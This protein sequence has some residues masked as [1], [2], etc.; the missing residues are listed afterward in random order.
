[1]ITMDNFFCQHCGENPANLWVTK[2]MDGQV[3]KQHLCDECFRKLSGH[4]LPFTLALPI[5][6]MNPLIS[7]T[8]TVRPLKS[9]DFQVCKNCSTSWHDFMQTGFLGCPQ[10]YENFKKQL[11]PL[12]KDIH[13]SLNYRGKVPK[14]LPEGIKLKASLRQLKQKL[15]S[16]IDIEDYEEAARIRDEMNELKKKLNNVTEDIKR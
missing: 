1:M 3:S 8:D 11:E 10:C 16:S 4:S 9:A 12:I 5:N 14:R 13:S 6:M 7:A 15:F 2:I